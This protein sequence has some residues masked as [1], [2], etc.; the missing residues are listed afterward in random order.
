MREVSDIAPPRPGGDDNGTSHETTDTPAVLQGCAIVGGPQRLLLTAFRPAQHA[1]PSAADTAENPPRR[2]ASRSQTCAD[3]RRALWRFADV[4]MGVAF[5]A[6]IVLFF[7]AHQAFWRHIARCST[8]TLHQSSSLIAGTR[9]YYCVPAGPRGRHAVV[10][11]AAPADALALYSFDPDRD[12]PGAPAP[13]LRV[14]AG[15]ATLTEARPLVFLTQLYREGYHLAYT[16]DAVNDSSAVL[17]ARA[18]FGDQCLPY[19]NAPT[20]SSSSRIY[21]N[22]SDSSGSEA[23][24]SEMVDYGARINATAPHFRGATAVALD[25]STARPVLVRYRIAVTVDAFATPPEAARLRPGQPAR[26]TCVA[27]VMRRPAR[28]TTDNTGSNLVGV[29]DAR[30]DLASF[31]VISTHSAGYVT[32]LA[33]LGALVEA[34]F[35]LVLVV[36]AIRSLRLQF[37]PSPTRDCRARLSHEVA[38]TL[39]HLLAVDAAAATAAAA[40]ETRETDSKEGDSVSTEKVPLL[41]AEAPA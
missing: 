12:L 40:A 14:Y 33:L 4:V 15:T 8:L 3:G 39:A 35:L 20:G 13:A 26:G 6:A 24:C 32:G 2:C 21:R 37:A 5:V 28:N 36:V 23:A 25:V 7:P 16:V 1:S 27:L 10:A 11:T 19:L 31:H 41:S 22:S 29:A 38:Q 34:A 9:T 30:R 18:R 17:C